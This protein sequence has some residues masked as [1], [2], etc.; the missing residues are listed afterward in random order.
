MKFEP[1]LCKLCTK[2]ETTLY[3]VQAYFVRSSN[4]LCMK[5]VK[6]ELRIVTYFPR[7]LY[8]C[9]PTIQVIIY[10]TGKHEQ[11]RLQCYELGGIL[12]P[13]G[14]TSDLPIHAQET[15]HHKS[16]DTYIHIKLQDVPPPLYAAVN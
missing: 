3:K 10:N 2:F 1:T 7:L 11:R 15:A 12:Y 14:K 8:T 13:C 5:F 16:A 9:I 4:L 6:Y